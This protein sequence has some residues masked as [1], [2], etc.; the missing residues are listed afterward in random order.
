M[1]HI[2]V[3]NLSIIASD[4]GLSPGLRQAIN[5]TNAGPLKTNL[6]EIF[7][8]IFIQVNAIEAVVCKISAILFR[9]QFVKK[10]R[11]FFPWPEFEVFMQ[12]IQAT[13]Q[14]SQMSPQ[15]PKYAII[16]KRRDE[17]YEGVATK[18]HE[19][20]DRPACDVTGGLCQSGNDGLRVGSVHI[21]G[22]VSDASFI[23]GLLPDLFTK[24]PRHSI[25]DTLKD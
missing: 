16:T 5:W 22:V 12:I 1:T 21:K 8:E 11:L 2:C 3:G 25:A 17:G 4:N 7:I 14:I 13:E 23:T 10:V 18:L 24:L 9:P 6:S 15:Y 20:I 19:V